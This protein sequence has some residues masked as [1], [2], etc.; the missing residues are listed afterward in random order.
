VQEFLHSKNRLGQ[1]RARFISKLYSIIAGVKFIEYY[2][3]SAIASY[4]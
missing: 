2:I 4:I 3:N 1:G